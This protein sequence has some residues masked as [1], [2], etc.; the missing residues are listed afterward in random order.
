MGKALSRRLIRPGDKLLNE[1]IRFFTF[2]R[3]GS[4]A[5]RPA[6]DAGLTPGQGSPEPPALEDVGQAESEE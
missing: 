3:P 1:P 2:N 6:E 4:A 5:R